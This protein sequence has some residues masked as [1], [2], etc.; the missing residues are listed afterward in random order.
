MQQKN[1]DIYGSNPIPWSRM[2][3][4]LEARDGHSTCWLATTA[5]D[6]R[7]Q[8]AG[9][10]GQWVD[11]KMDFT[12][13]SD[14]R[15]SRNLSH[16]PACAVSMSLPDVDLVIEG[17]AAIVTDASTL[18]LLAERYASQGWPAS[19]ADGAFMAPYSAPSAGPPPWHLYAITPVSA[20]AV[21]TREPNGATR[22][23]FD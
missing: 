7:P 12:S 19:V 16:N 18:A 6:G 20:V 21:A 3:T 4:Q 1:L 14:T 2:L 9:V 5:P 13:G 8:I 23:R 11:G 15:K 22:W 10:G 17:T